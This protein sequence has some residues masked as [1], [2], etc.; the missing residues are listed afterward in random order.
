MIISFAVIV[1]W[2]V[3]IILPRAQLAFKIELEYKRLFNPKIKSS[4][5]KFMHYLIPYHGGAR[6]CEL[7]GADVLAFASKIVGVTTVFAV[8]N[9]I[10]MRT[11]QVNID[12]YI[13]LTVQFNIL[14]IVLNY[15][16]LV[17][18]SYRTAKTTQAPLS[19][20]FS[21][22]PPASFY[23]QSCV[24]RYFFK[25]NKDDLRGTFDIEK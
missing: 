14:I 23:M 7:I 6:L 4:D 13:I 5:L 20:I 21:I 25:V 15:I 3:I 11:L 18:I 9:T 24:I 17:I 19:A 1:L 8:M 2:A 16:M 12:W 10:V 22:I